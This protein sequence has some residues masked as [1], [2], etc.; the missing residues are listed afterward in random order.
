MNALA[1]LRAGTADDHRRVE[2]LPFSL[3]MLHGHILLPHY[4]GWLSYLYDFHTFYER[5]LDASTDPSL[6]LANRLLSPHAPLLRADLAELQRL[7]GPLALPQVN[8]CLLTPGLPPAHHEG[9]F[10]LGVIYTMEGSALGSQVLRPR[11]R[12]ALALPDEALRYYT[13]RGHDTRRHFGQIAAFLDGQLR[14]PTT[15]DGAVRGARWAFSTLG[16]MMEE[17]W[18]KTAPRLA[19]VS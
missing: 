19:R 3:A 18:Q 4:A 13:G 14:D 17:L 6:T 2:Q 12:D 16:H 7:H 9:P 8:P 15:I 10:L 5:R 1:A 11:I